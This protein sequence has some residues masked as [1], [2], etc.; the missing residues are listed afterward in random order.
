MRSASVSPESRSSTRYSKPSSVSP[1]SRTPTRCSWRT[2]SSSRASSWKQS[3]TSA[4]QPAR[5]IETAFTATVSPLAVSRPSQTVL[6]A[7]SAIGRR[8]S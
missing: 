8:I 2:R 7:P 5:S 6:D 1:K 3:R 4:R